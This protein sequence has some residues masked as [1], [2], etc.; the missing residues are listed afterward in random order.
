MNP[1]RGYLRQAK[2]SSNSF[3]GPTKRLQILA[4]LFS[5]LAVFLVLRLFN[6]QVLQHSFYQALASGQHELYEKLFPSRGEISVQDRYAD[7]GLYTIA[8][9]NTLSLLY[10][11]PKH[12]DNV[13]ETVD[14]ILPYLDLDKE[15]VQTRLNKEDDLYE[16]LKHKVTEFEKGRIEKL[17]LDGIY[18]TDEDWRYYPEKNYMSHLTGFVGFSEDEKVG[19][20]GLEGYFDEE[21]SGVQGFLRSEKDAGGRLIPIGDKMIEE[22]V[23]GDDL[24]LTIDHNIQYYA[25]LKLQESVDRHGANKGSVIIV[26]PKTGAIIAMCNYPDFDPNYYEEEENLEVYMNT[27]VSDQYEPGSVFKIFTMAAGLDMGKVTPQTTYEDTGEVQIGPYTIM[28][29]DGSANGT[30]TMVDVLEKSLNTGSIFVADQ[31][32]ANNFYRYISNF[33]FGDK[34]GIDITGENNGDLSGLETGKEIYMATGSFGQGLTVTP[35]QLV[36]A[37]AAIANQGTL[38]KPYIVEK[39][40]KPDGT[41]MVSVPQEVRQIISP[42]TASSLAAMMVKVIDNGHAIRA[43]VDGYYM[44]GKTG[45]AQVPNAN[46]S[47]Y[48]AHRHKDS[49]VGF[50]PLAD[51][52]FVILAKID[53]PKDVLWSASSAAPLFGDI[54]EYIVNY[55]QI[56]PDKI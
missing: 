37:A 38:M 6:V 50:G 18:F 44:A 22:A 52:Q 55:L 30:Q 3:D 13:D 27:A 47:G 19:L 39:I 1:K 10:A 56:P 43:Q 32:G 12:I 24:V 36:M 35:I 5:L 40:I 15:T 2:K 33:G 21:L 23:D 53:E 4:V 8:T 41:E 48:D 14:K 20:Y 51:P 49:F 17:A 28:N 7:N 54:A 29:S 31:V 45:T 34:S 42:S 16:P 9:N 11:V 26:N 46:G 25:C